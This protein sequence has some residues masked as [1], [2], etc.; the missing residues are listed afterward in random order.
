MYVLYADM[1]LSAFL[2][3][4]FFNLLFFLNAE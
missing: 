1:L 4:N 3:I 2:I